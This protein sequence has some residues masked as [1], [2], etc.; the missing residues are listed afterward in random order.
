MVSKKGMRRGH[1]NLKE[2]PLGKKKGP[3]AYA[4]KEYE[5]TS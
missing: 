4:E 1:N 2:K 3:A 5:V